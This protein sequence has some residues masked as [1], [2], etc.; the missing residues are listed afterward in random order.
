MKN[1]HTCPK[2]DSNEIIKIA[3]PARVGHSKNQV[4][5]S[6]FTRANVDRYVCGVCGFSEEWISKTKDLRNI[7]KKYGKYDDFDE[8]V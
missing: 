3:G 6:L 8:Y 4:P 2:C 7:K 1:S 5:T